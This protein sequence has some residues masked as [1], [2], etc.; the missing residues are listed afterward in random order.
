MKSAEAE[1]KYKVKLVMDIP[2]G[3]DA[4]KSHEFE[5]VNVIDLN[6][7]RVL[8]MPVQIDEIKS[9]CFCSC[10]PHEAVVTVTLPQG[11]YVPNETIPIQCYI[12]N[13]TTVEFHS[14][15]FKLVRVVTATAATPRHSTRDTRDELW[16][17]EHAIEQDTK[18]TV[19]EFTTL[20]KVP[21]CPVSCHYA[22]YIQT[23][24]SI[25]VELHTSGCHANATMR[26]P[27]EIGTIP[28]GAPGYLSTSVVPL[29]PISVEGGAVPSAPFID[30]E[31]E[32]VPL[33]EGE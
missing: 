10:R 4:T 1:I 32:K 15:T 14:A 21:V 11:G 31:S 23:E 27:I 12:N 18:N 22:A 20:L 7:N 25:E 26:V 3:I 9:F 13:K 24:Y 19:T 6:Q 8:Q 5:V 33:A 2:W 17:E 30:Q 16:E 28:L 29:A